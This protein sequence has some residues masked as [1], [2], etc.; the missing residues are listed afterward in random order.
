MM[1]PNFKWGIILSNF[2]KKIRISEFNYLP[3]CFFR[4]TSNRFFV[5][6]R[7]VAQSERSQRR[8][9][10]KRLLSSS[11]SSS[12]KVSLWSKRREDT[13]IFSPA[14]KTQ[15]SSTFWLPRVPSPLLCSSAKDTLF[16]PFPVITIFHFSNVWLDFGRV[17]YVWLGTLDGELRFGIASTTASTHRSSLFAIQAWLPG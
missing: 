13:R 14:T 2:K 8:P 5:T 1:G 6:K 7:H 11:S 15:K 10:K 12:S 4:I 9:G 3:I 16:R 17:M